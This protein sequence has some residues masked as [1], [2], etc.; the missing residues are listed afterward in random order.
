VEE[1]VMSVFCRDTTMHGPHIAEVLN[2]QRCIGNLKPLAWHKGKHP[3]QEHDG[4]PRH[5]HSV[6]GA[7]T[8]APGDTKL[9]FQGTTFDAQPLTT[10][11]LA[12]YPEAFR[13]WFALGVRAGTPEEHTA[14][15]WKYLSPAERDF[16][17]SVT[18]R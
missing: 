17:R 3:W 12:E 4:Y 9:H 1:A 13:R 14:E 7:L 18:V 8:I 15:A 10:R 5:Q 11:V 16:W 2:F 6:N